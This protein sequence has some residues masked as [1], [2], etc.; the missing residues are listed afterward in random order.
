MPPATD[1]HSDRLTYEPLSAAHAPGLASVLCDPRVYEYIDAEI[2]T[3]ESLAKEFERLAAGAPEHRARETWIDFA[4][5][6]RSDH[7]LIGRIEATVIERNAEVAY[8][9]GPDYWGCGYGRESLRWLHQTLARRYGATDSWATITPANR[10]SLRLVEFFGYRETT[11]DTWPILTS[12]D[13]GDR[14]FHLS[15]RPAAKSSLG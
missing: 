6:R 5:R 2:P 7:T 9:F 8:L 11:A 1:S 10:R 3:P 4:V 14:V 15:L 13:P 12:Y